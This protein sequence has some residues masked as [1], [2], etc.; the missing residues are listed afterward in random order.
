MLFRR[1][2][3]SRSKYILFN[4]YML[5]VLSNFVIKGN[6]GFAN[7][8]K[9]V[10]DSDFGRGVLKTYLPVNFQLKTMLRNWNFIKVISS[11][12]RKGLKF[13]MFPC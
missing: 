6:F 12:R 11:T 10:K 8:S 3:E 4:L 13:Q 5:Y 7:L 2:E 1:L 9:S